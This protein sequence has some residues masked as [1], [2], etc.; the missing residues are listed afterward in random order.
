MHRDLNLDNILCTSEDLITV[1]VKICD[2]GFATSLNL[3][4]FP[5]LFRGT[6]EYIAPEILRGESQSLDCD[7]WSLGV[8]MF[9]MLTG[10][11]PFFNDNM[12]DMF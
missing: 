2:F 6:P 3:G 7:V 12:D 4:T 1:T 11:S 10:E 5:S 9:T 8:M